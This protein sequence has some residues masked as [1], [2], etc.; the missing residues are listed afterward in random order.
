[1]AEVEQLVA[2]KLTTQSV[3]PPEVNVTVPVAPPGKPDTETVSL[4][5]Y[6][7]LDGAADS[8]IEV[9][10]NVTVKLRRRARWCRCSWRCPS[11][12]R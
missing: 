2:G 10:D 9:L 11:R 6:W 3:D 7:T 5:P 8:V 12:S 4:V 1:M